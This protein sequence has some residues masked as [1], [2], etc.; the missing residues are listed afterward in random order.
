V[1]DRLGFDYV[2]EAIVSSA[3]AK[4]GISPTDVADAEKRKSVLSR[5]VRELGG[6]AGPDSYGFAG[7]SSPYLEGATPLRSAMHR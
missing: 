5:L 6:T 1:A 4:G 2:D 3:A 7:L